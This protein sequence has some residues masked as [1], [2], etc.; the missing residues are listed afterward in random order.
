MRPIENSGRLDDSEQ[1]WNDRVHFFTFAAKLMRRILIDHARRTKAEKRGGDLG[2]IPLNPEL[3][4]VGS[5]HEESLDLA[6]AFE[7]LE[8]LDPAKARAVELRYFL[9][10]T[11][12]ETASVLGL[13]PSSVDRSIRFSLAWLRERLH[14]RTG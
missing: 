9:G 7:E 8:A 3:A 6:A 10:C 5:M 4:W 12:E 11:V 13:S 14:T 1:G 2:R